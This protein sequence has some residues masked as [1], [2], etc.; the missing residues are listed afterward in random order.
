[1]A[2]CPGLFLLGSHFL[3]H[4][5]VVLNR[6]SITNS[7]CF[8]M[9]YGDQSKEDLNM[10]GSTAPVCTLKLRYNI[11]FSA[12]TLLVGQQEGHPACKN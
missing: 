9:H 1:M 4:L 11:A 10:F 7:L 12:L 8:G 2:F 3:C 5:F 6:T